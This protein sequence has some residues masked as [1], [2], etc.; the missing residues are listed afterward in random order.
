MVDTKD[1]LRN[2]LGEQ[3]VD[4]GEMRS[5]FQLNVL[6][7][8]KKVEKEEAWNPLTFSLSLLQHKEVK[9]SA[10]NTYTQTV[11]TLQR[12]SLYQSLKKSKAIWNLVVKQIRTSLS[13]QY[14]IAHSVVESSFTLHTF[15]I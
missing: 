5:P 9:Q 6:A 4:F 12:N 8:V 1:D 13:L 15:N 11:H 14:S 3:T 2:A 7:R 10:F